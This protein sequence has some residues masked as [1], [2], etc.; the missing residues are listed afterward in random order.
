MPFA[1]RRPAP[2]ARPWFFHLLLVGSLASGLPACSSGGDGE[3]G[4]PAGPSGP[5]AP[6]QP[7]VYTALGASDAMGI[8]ASTVCVP[9]TACPNGTG[10]VPTVARELGDAGAEVTLRNL[11]LPGAVL[12]PEV[13]QLGNS[14]GVGRDTNMLQQ[15]MPFVP[16]ESTLVTIFAGGNDVNT[17]ATA[18]DRGAAGSGDPNAFLDQHVQRFA[19][20]LVTLVRGVRER[21]PSARLIVLNLPNL[22][23]LPYARGLPT[24]ERRWMQRLAVGFAD[25]ANAL[26]RENATVVDLLCDP[27]S[28][29]GA[30]Y[31]SDGFH[32]N[33]AGYTFMAG[34]V[35]RAIDGQ[36]GPPQA[37]CRF[38]RIVQ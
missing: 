9:F 37:D 6:G 17:I 32:P 36:I 1:P 15:Q 38:M 16:R 10:Y 30:N 31:S 26:V 34:E 19:A 35:M 2:R 24:A 29:Q 13:Q 12:S 33:D 20:D 3:P 7:V 23:A 21:A 27:R 22:A 8:G 4:S 14:V 11:G 18:V 28:Y 25:S 5:P